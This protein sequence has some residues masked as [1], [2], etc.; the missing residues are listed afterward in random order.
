M[1]G[2][3]NARD[4]KVMSRTFN[5][6]G[7]KRYKTMECEKRRLCMTDMTREVQKSK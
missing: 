3:F 1:K 7:F 2:A 4:M 5:E 6:F